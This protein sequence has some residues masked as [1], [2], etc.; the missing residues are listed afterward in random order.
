MSHLG[1]IILFQLLCEHFVSKINHF[2]FNRSL[3]SGSICSAVNR[4]EDV[5][6]RTVKSVCPPSTPLPPPSLP[7]SAQPARRRSAHTQS[8]NITVC[9]II[10]D[11]WDE[12][13]TSLP[14]AAHVEVSTDATVQ[15]NS[16]KALHLQ[17]SQQH[18]GHQP[19]AGKGFHQRRWRKRRA[20]GTYTTEGLLKQN[21]NLS[22]LVKSRSE[23]M[24]VKRLFHW[25]SGAGGSRWTE[26]SVSP[27]AQQQQSRHGHAHTVSTRTFQ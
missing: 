12:P 8:H 7:L 1:S 27:S 9:S 14:A 16:A 22:F 19:R 6:V 4:V 26:G 17:S 11:Q 21:I 20:K 2:G 23:V 5:S 10:C 13:V 18:G 3:N 25:L 15:H 24:I